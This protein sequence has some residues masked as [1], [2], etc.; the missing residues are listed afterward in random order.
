MFDADGEM[1]GVSTMITG[2]DV[3]MAVPVHVAKGFL[4]EALRAEQ[5]AA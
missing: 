3:A 1:V 2:P 4:Q 5:S